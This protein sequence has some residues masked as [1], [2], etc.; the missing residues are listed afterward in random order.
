MRDAEMVILVPK[1]GSSGSLNVIDLSVTLNQAFFDGKVNAANPLDRWYPLPRLKNPSSE[2]GEAVYV[3]YDDLTKDFV[4]QGVRPFSFLLPNQEP[5][6]LG[7]LEAWRCSEFSFFI[8]DKNRSL[9]GMVTSA[10]QLRPISVDNNSFT[11]LYAFPKATDVP[12]IAISFNFD[13]DEQDADIRMIIAS[14]IPT[15][16]LLTLKGLVDVNAKYS[17]ITTTGFKA[18]LTLDFGSALNP[19][20]VGGLLI[21][22]FALFNVN[23]SLAVTISTMTENPDGTYAFTFAAQTSGHKLRLTPTKTKFDF[24]AVVASLVTIP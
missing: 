11:P 24:S 19:K 8:V 6:L 7:K 20:T 13:T 3:D 5:A 22:D 17:N 1:Y 4:H 2:R 16:N 18:A 9:I 21:G 15:V 10:G 14:E 12:T 23:T